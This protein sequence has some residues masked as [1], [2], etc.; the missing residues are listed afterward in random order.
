MI[1]IVIIITIVTIVM[2]RIISIIIIIIIMYLSLL[3]TLAWTTWKAWRLQGLRFN[4]LGFVTS[5]SENSSAQDYR[6][7]GRENGGQ[8]NL[9]DT[10][11]TV[12]N[13]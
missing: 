2:I 11:L 6:S 10:D 3:L 9:F 13:R 5:V 7:V 12:D 4:H 8:S 1:T